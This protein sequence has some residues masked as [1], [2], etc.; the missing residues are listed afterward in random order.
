MKPDRHNSGVPS[1]V[2]V[3]R[4][5]WQVETVSYG[6]YEEVSMRALHASTLAGV[7]ERRPSLKVHSGYPY[8]AEGV[9]CAFDAIELGVSADAGEDL[10]VDR[11]NQQR[12]SPGDA[13][14]QIHSE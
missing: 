13:L 8:E 2:I 5:D 14:T 9:E 7:E 4:Q 1:K 3:R 10:L 12:L 11:A 6:A